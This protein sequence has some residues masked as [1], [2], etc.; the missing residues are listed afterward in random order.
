MRR[1]LLYRF[2]EG[3]CSREEIEKIRVWVNSSPENEKVFFEESALFDALQVSPYPKELFSEAPKRKSQVFMRELLKIA[4]I[5]LLVFSGIEGWRYMETL[6]D[7]HAMN[8]I[9][10]PAGKSANLTLS[11]GSKVWLNACSSLR[12]LSTFKK[13]ER[14]VFLEG[15]AY[16]EVNADKKHPFIVHT[17]THDV[18]VY[19]TS[20]HVEATSDRFSVALMEG[21]LQVRSSSLKQEALLAPGHMLFLENGLLKEKEITDYNPYRWRE[22]L[23]CFDNISFME[24]MNL[25]EKYYA[26]DIDVDNTSVNNY[27]C[28]GK[29][30][31]S[32]GI[33]YALNILR[34]DVQFTFEREEDM[35]IIHIK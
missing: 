29:F 34:K 13:N 7:S 15:E 22:G 14:N 30:R 8:I 10:V 19:G 12:Y 11:D 32:D 23:I 35:N 3:S 1:K 18:Q 24:L 28:T 33:D 16:F 25:F 2:F 6:D 21:S 5:A 20:F 26:V 17:E 9:E 31:Q 4:A 27:V